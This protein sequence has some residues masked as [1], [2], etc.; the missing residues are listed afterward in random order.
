MKCEIGVVFEVAS[1][2]GVRL[3]ELENGSLSKQIKQN[4]DKLALLP[5]SA[6]KSSKAVDDKF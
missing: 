1:I 4:Q 3:F 5:R 6:R 2:V